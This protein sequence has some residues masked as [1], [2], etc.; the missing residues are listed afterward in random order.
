MDIVKPTDAELEILQVLWERGGST[1]REVN[2]QLSQKREIG[3]TTTLKIMQLMHEKGLV[4]READADLRERS[5]KGHLYMAAVDREA[6]QRVL[7]DRFVENTFSGSAMQLVMQA[8]GGHHAS[9]AEIDQIRAYL[10]T[11]EN[12]A[13]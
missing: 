4:S 2:E 3:Y 10:D 1:V 13:Q 8:L 12:D 5:G 6:T 11:L 7:L 9:P